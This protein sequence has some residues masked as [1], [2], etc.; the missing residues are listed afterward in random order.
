M[1]LVGK[2]GPPLVSLP[3]P[4]RT[5]QAGNANSG[6]NRYRSPGGYGGVP[7]GGLGAG[8]VEIRPDGS[9]RKWEIFNNWGG[10]LNTR[11]W[12][13]APPH[14]L[15]NVFAALKLAGRAFVLETGPPGGL[16]GLKAVGYHGRF[17]FA[18]LTYT[19][20]DS[21]PLEMT[22]EAFSSYIP[23]RAAESA[24]PAF[25]L[26]YTLKNRSVSPVEVTLALSQVNP[27]GRT[28]RVEQVNG[29][30]VAVCDDG[31]SGLALMS[32]DAKPVHVL[33]G[34]DNAATLQSFWADFT[35]P[36]PLQEQSAA[37]GQRIAQAV[38]VSIAAGQSVRQRF[39]VGWYFPD[40]REGGLG[41]KVG[42]RYEQWTR[43]AA[44]SAGTPGRAIRRSSF[45]LGRVARHPGRRLLARLGLRLAGE[46]PGQ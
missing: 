20:P 19:L 12:K 23:F 1:K 42:H 36:G 15:L 34:P 8:S 25:A 27:L 6:F 22:L 3:P 9:L 28:C 10:E 7:L 44:Q 40:H 13:Y 16:P 21:T 31:R 30:A 41:P 5:D 38:T 24:I 4:T 46:L 33:G 43:S 18:D 37:E 11:I 17:P 39:V 32:L 14:D 26:T 45:R 35:K 2:L 29:R